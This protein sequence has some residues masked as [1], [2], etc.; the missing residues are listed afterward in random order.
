MGIGQ[1][2]RPQVPGPGTLEDRGQDD[3]DAPAD[4]KSLKNVNGIPED[5]ANAKQVKI[6]QEDRGFNG[7]KDWTIKDFDTINDLGTG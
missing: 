6:E 3:G 2:W 4:N 7:S 1:I 5:S